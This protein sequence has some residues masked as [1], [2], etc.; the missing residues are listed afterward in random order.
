MSDIESPDADRLLAGLWV[1]DEPPARDPAFVIAAMERIERRRLLEG[2]L[3]L[4]PVA[5]GASLLL[6]AFAPVIA[7]AAAMVRLDAGV[8]GPVAGGL[9]MAL[10]LWSWA[11]DRLRPLEV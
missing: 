11:S 2:V 8:T 4:V 9:V 6:W 3:A 5:L 10:F 1:Q 7:A